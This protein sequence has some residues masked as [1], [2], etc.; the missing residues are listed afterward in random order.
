MSTAS[1]GPVIQPAGR[2][3][4]AAGDQ[5]ALNVV[6]PPEEYDY[7]SL[8]PNFSLAANMA[9]GAFAGIAEHSV[10]YPVDLLKTRLQ[11]VNPTPAAIYT[12]LGNAISTISRAEGYLSLW[13][14][15]SSVVLGAGED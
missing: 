8:P 9:A 15:V 10:M 11:V 4:G 7:E 12:G 2:M 14:G 3:A 6:E 5:Q 1:A 13:R